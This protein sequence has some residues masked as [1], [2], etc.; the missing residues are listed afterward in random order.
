[1]LQQDEPEDY[2]I[3]SGATHS[4]GEFVELAFKHAGLDWKEYVVV[5]PQLVRPAEVDLLLGDS[6]KARQKLGWE[7]TVDFEH[8][9]KLMVDAD[10]ECV[11]KE[12]RN[13]AD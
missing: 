5:D 11:A 6:T 10:L 1:M 13:S 2:V 12:I 7:P 8:L 9:V 3:S 4:V